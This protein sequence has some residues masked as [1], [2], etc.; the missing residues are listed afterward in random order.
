MA[1]GPRLSVALTRD[2]SP[3]KGCI[4]KRGKATVPRLVLVLLEVAER[5]KAERS[6]EESLRGKP[7]QQEILKTEQKG[8]GKWATL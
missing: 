6:G 8:N 4:K 3:C 7:L 2:V 1:D 5:E